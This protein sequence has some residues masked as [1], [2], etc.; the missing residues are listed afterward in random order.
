MASFFARLAPKSVRAKILL[1]FM[2]INLVATSAYTGYLYALKAGA[3]TDEID[4]RL[5]AAAHAAPRMIGYD[6]LERPHGPGA[7]GEAQYLPLVRMLYGYC[8][9]IGLRYLYV[10]TQ[11]QGQVIYLMDSASDQE[12]NAG[13][14]GRYWSRYD[15]P[16]PYLWQTFHS[17]QPRYAEYR[18]RYGHFRSIFLPLV[19]RDGSVLVIGADIDIRYVKGEL[20]GALHQAL[21]IGAA[22]FLL[23]A[24]LSLWLARLIARP[25]LVLAEAAHH[26]AQGDYTT[27]IDATDGD[28][29]GTLAQAFGRMSQA[30]ASR[31][32]QIAS[33]AFDDQLTGLPN[34]LRLSQSLVQEIGRGE[35]FAV[36]MIDIDR[37]KYIN[38]YLGYGAGDS[39][40]KS[41]AARLRDV[42]RPGDHLARLSGD[43]FVL[44]LHGVGLAELA[45]VVARFHRVLENPLAIAGQTVDV[46]GSTGVAL[47]PLHGDVANTLIHHAE[48]A[49]Y[50]AKRTHSP[51]VVYDPQQEENRKNV[52]SLLSELKTAVDG[53][54]LVAFLQPK[55]A[56]G[57]GRVEGVEALVRW[58]H[59]ERGWIS[60]AQFIPFAEQSGRI[61][62]L[63]LWMLHRCLQLN[64]AWKESGRDIGIAVNVSISDLEDADFV[65]QVEEL[66][67]RHSTARGMTLE[68]TESAVM[69]APTTVLPALERLREL[70]F[71]LA[72]DD[73]GTGYSSLAYLSKLP[74]DE[75]KI[76]RSFIT[77][78]GD[79]HG[80]GIVRAVV[81]LGHVL[82]LKVVAE[83]V[84]TEAAWRYLQGLQCDLAQGYLV[85]KP[86]A[87][88][89]FEDWLKLGWRVPD[90]AGNGR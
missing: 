86:M 4:A 48:T 26:I 71:K 3:I 73:F 11:K 69:S 29:L 32:K 67:A 58:R 10:F 5:K 36:V 19:R 41:I 24:L 78:L 43:E 16:T 59:P 17:R 77:E 66:L 13:N 15:D 90:K 50:I 34:R 76:D 49:M 42:L 57:D 46:A 7:I 54:Q 87:V 21:A 75:L 40:L 28:E 68:I 33:L 51:F 47:Y 62:S 53:D 61:R 31:E 65:P 9:T 55:V 39:A 64:N 44:V 81:E 37:F 72:I 18:D 80:E 45:G 14:Y 82:G 12:I 20:D 85:A 89:A 63:T 8:Q 22:L 30:I 83:G 23:G 35:P 70:G 79:A 6:Y 38:D 56:L 88:E 1:M 60:P 25:L 2:T 52:L 74:V 27:A 84:E